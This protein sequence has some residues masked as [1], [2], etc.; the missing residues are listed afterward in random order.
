MNTG[1]FYGKDQLTV[2]KAIS[3]ARKQIKGS[4]DDETIRKVKESQHFVQRMVDEEKTVYGVTTGFGILANTKINEEDAATLQYKILQSHSVGVGEPIPEEM[5]RLMMITKVHSLAQG[6]SGVQLSTIQRILWHLEADVIPVVPE[7]GSVGASGDL[8]PL[9][10]LFLP[11]IGLGEVY[12]KD[13]KIPGA[14]LLQ[15]EGL[16]PVP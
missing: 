13:K 2:K 1:F 6:Y 7:K 11:L 10:H 16:A 8:A 15:Q 4:L 5:V 9:A 12:Y 3:L 14:A